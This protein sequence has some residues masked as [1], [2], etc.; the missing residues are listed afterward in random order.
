MLG[1]IVAACVAACTSAAVRASDVKPD[2]SPAASGEGQATQLRILDYHTGEVRLMGVVRKTDEEW[3]KQ[4][5]PEQYAVTRKKATERAFTGRYHDH[6]EPGVYRCVCC[7]ID[8]YSSDTKFD[9][10]TGW[11]SFWAPVAP[12]HVQLKADHSLFMQRTEVLC[13]RC[14]A[15]LGHVFNDGPPPTRQRHCINSASLQ[16]HRPPA[17]RHA[18]P[19]GTKPQAPRAPDQ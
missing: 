6:K 5:T 3:K 12:Q 11:P 19:G 16:F 13:A 10:G 4:L 1:M 18:P 17:S 7:G 14:G 2:P 9:S 8:L 15:H